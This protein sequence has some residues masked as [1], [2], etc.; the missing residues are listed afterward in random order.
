MGGYLIDGYGGYL[1][2]CCLEGGY[3]GCLVFGILV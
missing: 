3:E 2:G 1:V